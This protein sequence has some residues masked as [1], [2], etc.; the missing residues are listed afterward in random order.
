MTFTTS[1]AN[2]N[3]Y[4]VLPQPMD[5]GFAC[6]VGVGRSTTHIDFSINKQS[7]DSPVDTGSLAVQVTN[8]S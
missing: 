4:Y 8:Y 1:Y 2:S 5:Q 6:Y 7:D 3:D